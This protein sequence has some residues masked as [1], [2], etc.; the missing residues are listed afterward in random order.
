[1]PKEIVVTGL[2]NRIEYATT[3]GR[4]L[5]TG[6]RE[7][8][9]DKAIEAVFVHLMAE[10]GRRNPEG[11]AFGKRYGDEGSVLYVAPGVK[12]VWEDEENED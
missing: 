5:V 10:K 8:I 1:M 9:T 12:L 4:G 2:G 7:D 6:K 3:N 11:K